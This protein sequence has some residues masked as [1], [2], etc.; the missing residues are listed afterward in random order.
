MKHGIFVFSLLLILF[1]ER[2]SPAQ[3][4]IYA[5][6]NSP[7][8]CGDTLKL[9]SACGLSYQW[10]GPNGFYSDLQNPTIPNATVNQSG[11]YNL[12]MVTFS[13]DTITTSPEIIVNPLPSANSGPPQS[14][15]GG[16][17]TELFGLAEN[18]LGGPYAYHWVP[19]NLFINPD[20][21]HAITVNLFQTTHF[22]LKVSEPNTGCISLPDTTVVYVCGPPPGFKPVLTP[23]VICSGNNSLLSAN[24]GADT[25]DFLHFNWSSDPPEFTSVYANNHIQPS[26]N[27][28]YYLTVTSD[29]LPFIYTDSI[30]LI[31]QQNPPASPTL[32]S[33]PETLCSG[34]Q[35]QVYHVE[36]VADAAYYHWILP[37]GVS[38]ISSTD[39]I[40]LDFS[41]EAVSGNIMVAAGNA[42][43]LSPYLSEAITLNHCPVGFSLDTLTACPGETLI[44]PVT[45]NQF[46]DI[47][48]INLSLAFDTNS[49]VFQGIEQVNPAINPLTVDLSTT[50][51]LLSSI[52]PFGAWIPD[53]DTLLVLKFNYTG[54]ST[55]LNWADVQCQVFSGCGT[56]LDLNLH[57]GFISAGN[58]PT[59]LGGQLTYA[60]SNILLQGVQVQLIK[61]GN[62]IAETTSGDN[63]NYQFHGLCP[64]MYTLSLQSSLPWGGVNS[65]DALLVLKHFTGVTQLNPMQIL[66]ADVDASGYVNSTDALQIARRFTGII[67]SF[68]AGD[69][70]FET[71]TLSILQPG[72]YQQNLQ[73]LCAGD[74]NHSFLPGYN[75][76]QVCGDTFTDL[77]N[78]KKYPTVQI[79]NQCWFAK[80]LNIGTKIQYSWTGNNN[81]IL[82]KHCLSN[83]ESQ[84]E[85]WGGV[86]HW[87]ELMQYSNTPT[88]QGICPQGFHIPSK[89]EWDTLVLFLG[90]STVAGGKLKATGYDYWNPPNSGATNE[91]GFSALGSGIL[92][93]ATYLSAYFASSTVIEDGTLN[94]AY[95]LHLSHQTGFADFYE[96]LTNNF[97]P[98]FSVRCIKN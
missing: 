52:I 94:F 21:Q 48:S 32:L 95:V 53:G 14:I 73:G 1:S 47:G 12:Q 38:G 81:G 62:L 10:T 98:S 3:S 80:N 9:L 39:T 45:L 57:H 42:C 61:E 93:G 36:P 63:G 66:A 96:M 74:I 30:T 91:C 84:C 4:L 65:I 8:C 2:I 43:G 79:G 75:A 60:G 17:Y 11:T 28:T 77:R 51:L 68:P 76:F 83:L 56:N 90:G 64:G 25:A 40:V 6:S 46:N 54:G 41:Q 24:F 88:S 26:V 15:I 33:G 85:I 58:L 97:I 7:L 71:A 72:N 49:L 29:Y 22:V 82:E 44:V 78:G 20:L 37:S 67:S 19:E 13:G 87:V 31:V 16:C 89:E 86:Y 23:P 27:T 18:G 59:D 69:W 70:V 55:A 34:M 92:S 50:T 35:N 5:K